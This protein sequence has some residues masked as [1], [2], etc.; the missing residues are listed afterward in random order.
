[1]S[2]I[3]RRTDGVSIGTILDGTIDTSATSLTLVGRNYANYGQL[4]VD[5]LVKL[6]ESFAYDIPP[7][8]PLTGQLWYDTDAKVLKVWSGTLFKTV[9]A[10]TAQNTAPATT[11]AGDFWWDTN[12]EQLYVYNG[13]DPFAVSGWILIGPPYSKLK[14]KSG[15]LW[16]QIVD[17]TAVV[18][19]VVSLYLNGVRTGI[20]SLDGDF[21]PAESIPGF[22]T[23][24]RGYNLIGTGIMN[25]ISD[26]ANKLGGILA[27][28][29]L[30]ADIADSTSGAL[31]VANDTGLAVGVSSDFKVQVND[32]DVELANQTLGGSM[33]FWVN[34]SGTLSQSLIIDGVTGEVSVAGS[35]T[36]S[37]GVA[38]KFYVDNK[39]N[40]S[41]LTGIPVAPTAAPGTNTTQLA[42]TEFV[43]NSLSLNK[44]YQGN[45]FVEIIDT[46][47]GYANVVI[48]GIQVLT[49]TSGGVALRNGATAVTQSQSVNNGTIATTSYVRTAVQRWDGSAKFVSLF[50]PDPGVNDVGSIDGDFWF[51]YT[52]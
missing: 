25:G 44:I 38:T 46:G 3:I 12:D 20:I 49:A 10:A 15:A 32:T 13:T 17:N 7:S 47:A 23:I 41:V 14:G 48:D 6:L 1:M 34:L 22:T 11:V 28:N 16:E 33:S 4:M 42:T 39:F 5:N 24:T 9:G 19:D 26:D 52:P 51:Q 37:L 27:A 35:P 2:Y 21:V 45:S 43:N 50:A 31:T 40:N 36:T 30:R 29:Y 18:H 8:N